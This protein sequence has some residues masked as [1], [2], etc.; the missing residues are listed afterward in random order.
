MTLGK[1]VLFVINFMFVSCHILQDI[2]AAGTDTTYTG[3]TWAM[4]ELIKNPRVLRKLQEEIRLL[5]HGRDQVTEED[6]GKM[7][8]LKAVVKETLRLHHFFH[9]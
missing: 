8:Y 5:M 2:F 9:S 6:T 3:L 7:L 4:V 1:L